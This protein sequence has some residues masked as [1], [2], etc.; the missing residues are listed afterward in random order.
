M[1]IGLYKLGGSSVRCFNCDNQ[2]CLLPM[3]FTGSFNNN[4]YFTPG[5]RASW[6]RRSR[7]SGGQNWGRKNVTRI[8]V[9]RLGGP[10]HDKF[11][12]NRFDNSFYGWNIN[13]HGP[14][15]DNYMCPTFI[16]LNQDGSTNIIGNS[17]ST[18]GNR[19]FTIRI[20]EGHKV[21]KIKLIRYDIL[22]NDVQDTD[23]NGGFFGI[24]P[25][26]TFPLDL[27]GRTL[28]DTDVNGNYILVPYLMGGF[29]ITDQHISSE[30]ILPYFGTEGNL[31]TIFTENIS[32]LT[33]GYWTFWIREGGS[34]QPFEWEIQFITEKI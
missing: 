5:N 34:P 7:A 16:N 33:N 19:L 15:S 24:V 32:K 23:K 13:V 14:L 25:G 18:V 26:D 31:S 8:G 12:C 17:G 20:D 22:E 30:T 1:S 10:R 21:H 6:A 9:N 3:N 4:N 28:T 29:H 11:Y 2:H 27:R